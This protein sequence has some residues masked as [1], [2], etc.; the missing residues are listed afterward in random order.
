MKKGHRRDDPLPDGLVVVGAERDVRGS[1]SSGFIPVIFT[2]PPSGMAPIPYSVSP[3]CFFT[4]NGGKNRP[5]LDAHATR[6]GGDE[7]AELVQDDQRGEARECEEPAQARTA[8]CSTSD[9]AA[10]RASVSAS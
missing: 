5:A 4:T 6:L 8:S 10:A 2:K 7:V 1:S 3:I 9:A